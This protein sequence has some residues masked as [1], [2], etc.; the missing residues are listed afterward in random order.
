[1]V[2]RRGRGGGGGGGAA[3]LDDGG[4]ALLHDGNEFIGIPAEVH[5]FQRGLAADGGVVQVRILRGGMV[6]PDG[7][8]AHVVH[9]PAEL[10]GDLIKG[11]VVVQP[12][13]GRELPPIEALGVAG[14]NQGVGVGRIA[15]H[16]HADVAARMLV[17][18]LALDRED[19]R[20][21]FQQI[22][23][24]HAW[25]ARAGA[26]QQGVIGV[27]ESFFRSISGDDLGQQRKRTIVEFHHHAVQGFLRLRHFQELQDHRL[28][29]AKHGTR[30]NAEVQG[31]T[32]LAGGAGYC[33]AYRFFHGRLRRV[34]GTGAFTGVCQ[35]TFRQKAVKRRVV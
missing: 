14:G 30:G 22:L 23:A 35:T 11:A 19:L 24:L 12:S 6:A 17:H 2:D 16:Q 10:G 33:D 31:V 25:S 3:R 34:R 20:I 32:D 29:R 26:D 18:R 13:H 27:L 4:A 15:D 7:D 9:V 8:P 5:L 28:V 1:M 21:G